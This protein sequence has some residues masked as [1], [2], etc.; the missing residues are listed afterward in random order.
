VTLAEVL[1]WRKAYDFRY[2]ET[3]ATGSS[4]T[5][6]KARLR[7]WLEWLSQFSYSA[8]LLVVCVLCISLIGYLSGF[9]NDISIQ[10]KVLSEE[11][12]SSIRLLERNTREDLQDILQL[13]EVTKTASWAQADRKN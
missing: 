3:S 2:A 12:S 1:D 5:T 10:L 9:K 6:R 8:F 4:A 11:N 13:K 7:A